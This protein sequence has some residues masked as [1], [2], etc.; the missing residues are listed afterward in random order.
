MLEDV[1]NDIIKERTRQDER[2]GIQHHSDE[3]SDYFAW[4]SF[5]K[6]SDGMRWLNDKRVDTCQ[7]AWDGIL[8]EELVEAFEELGISQVNLRKELIEV[9]AVCVAWVQDI[10]SRNE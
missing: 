10:D 5:P 6:T 7:L 9:A 4:Q 2:W 8:Y 1:I 3:S